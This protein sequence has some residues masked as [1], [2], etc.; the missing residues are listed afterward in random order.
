MRQPLGSTSDASAVTSS[1]TSSRGARLSRRWQ[2]RT[3]SD[4]FDCPEYDCELSFPKREEVLAHL[5]W[6]HNRSEYK[7]K[8]MLENA[9][10][11]GE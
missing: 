7:A 6:D 11:E 2:V 1:D 5:E 9:T 8:Q 4:G 10:E 3:V